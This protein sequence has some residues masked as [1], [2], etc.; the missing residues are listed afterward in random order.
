MA[1]IAADTPDALAMVLATS[2]ISLRDQA[3]RAVKY[4]LARRRFNMAGETGAICIPSY[5][6]GGAIGSTHGWYVKIYCN[7]LPLP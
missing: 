4:R 7:L 1:A 2:L 5:P 6:A 3:Q